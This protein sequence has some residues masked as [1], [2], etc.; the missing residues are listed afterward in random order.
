MQPLTHFTEERSKVVSRIQELVEVTREICR[1]SPDTLER[2]IEA[3]KSL[4][5]LTYENLNQIL[6][7]SMIL[8]AVEYLIR[9][10]VCPPETEWRWNPRQTGG[11][12]EPDLLGTLS[13]HILISAEITTS[14]KPQGVLATRMA[15]TLAKLAT[16]QGR[17]FYFVCS[18][19]MRDRAASRV[20]ELG[21]SIKVVRL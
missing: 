6:H 16:M 21:A 10:G 15:A 3:L 2:G 11:K 13:G 1:L 17:R 12:E 20:A 18:D 9:E 8:D 14:E 4:R 7:E 19:A 5:R